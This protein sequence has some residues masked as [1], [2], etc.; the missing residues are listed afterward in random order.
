[1]SKKIPF[2]SRSLRKAFMEGFVRDVGERSR[3]KRENVMDPRN[4]LEFQHGRTWKSPANEHGDQDGELTLHS[5]ETELHMKDIVNGNPMVIFRTTEYI[6]SK[7]HDS[8]MSA[9]FDKVH[10][11]TSNSGNV[12]NTTDGS[13]PNAMNDMLEMLVPS[14]DENGELQMPTMFVAPSQGEKIVTELKAA[15]PEFEKHI[16][17][18][19][20]RKKLEAQANED[21]RRK[22]FERHE[23]E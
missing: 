5:T 20:E 6:S 16:E 15:G 18:L 11:A 10:A 9:M 21:T 17:D 4:V 3:L 2:I 12:V 8:F 1:V 19:K 7:M 14:L 22:K 23:I 13:W